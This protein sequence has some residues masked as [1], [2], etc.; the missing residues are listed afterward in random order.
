MH[1]AYS[2]LQPHKALITTDQVPIYTWYLGRERHICVYNLPKVVISATQLEDRGWK[3]QHSR[4][5]PS[6][7]TTAPQRP[8]FVSYPPTSCVSRVL[9]TGCN[10]VVGTPCATGHWVF[11]IWTRSTTIECEA[12]NQEKIDLV[13]FVLII[14]R[15]IAGARQ[16]KM[17]DPDVH[18]LIKLFKFRRD[19]NLIDVSIFSRR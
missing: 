19:K 18:C 10:V 11:K 14:L 1:I 15:S 3:P 4:C 7:L 9:W 2:M 16:N 8:R 5:E 13:E 6:T 12:K 17:V